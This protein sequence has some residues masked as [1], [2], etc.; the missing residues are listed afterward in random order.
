MS[1]NNNDNKSHI[2]MT[3]SISSEEEYDGE[4]TVDNIPEEEFKQMLRNPILLPIYYWEKVTKIISFKSHPDIGTGIYYRGTSPFGVGNFIDE[5]GELSQV[6]PTAEGGWKR[7][8]YQ[9]EYKLLFREYENEK[10]MYV[11]GKVNESIW[12]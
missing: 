2:T 3:S 9:P 4:Y 12:E 8:C 11:A 10:Y 5:N 6:R 1:D 7:E